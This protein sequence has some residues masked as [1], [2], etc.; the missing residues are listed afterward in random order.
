M[1]LLG[2]SIGIPLRRQSEA[3]PLNECCPHHSVPDVPLRTPS[4]EEYRVL[5]VSCRLQNDVF[6]RALIGRNQATRCDAARSLVAGLA[7]ATTAC[8]EWTRNGRL[9]NK[10]HSEFRS[11]FQ[12]SKS[13]MLFIV[14]LTRSL[15]H[16]RHDG[17]P[18]HSI[19]ALLPRVKF[20]KCP[21]AF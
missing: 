16:G 4:R 7:R 1:K 21:P 9:R 20:Q 12:A 8:L 13:A 19:F 17:A 18:D 6:E 15:G 10:H 11:S 5:S 3:S 2:S 14:A